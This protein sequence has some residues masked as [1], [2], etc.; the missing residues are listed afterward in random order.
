M[1]HSKWHIFLAKSLF[2][3]GPLETKHYCRRLIFNWI[4]RKGRGKKEGNVVR[5]SP[6]IQLVLVKIY[7]LHQVRDCVMRW[8]LNIL[9]KLEIGKNRNLCCFWMLLM[10]PMN[11]YCVFH[12]SRGWG[13]NKL[14]IKKFFWRF[15]LNH[16]P[17]TLSQTIRKIKSVRAFQRLIY[18]PKSF[19]KQA[20]ILTL[21]YDKNYLELCITV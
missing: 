8:I 2:P 9:T 4:Q 21:I 5:D 14:E 1:R 3:I 12:F 11:S 16:A 19:Y 10:F 17:S 7:P 18:T 13:E 20:S 6:L 15:L